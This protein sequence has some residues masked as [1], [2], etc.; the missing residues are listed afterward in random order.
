MFRIVVSLR[1]KRSTNSQYENATVGVDLEAS[2]LELS[3][4]EEIVGRTRQLFQIARSAVQGELLH[5]IPERTSSNGHT[6]GPNGNDHANGNGHHAAGHNGNGHGRSF[7]RPSPEPS[8]K[9]RVLLKRLADERRLTAEQVG[10]IARRDFGKNVPQLDRN[11][12]S[13]LLE[14]LMDQAVRP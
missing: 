3:T 7:G 1:E 11:E 13:R 5:A 4:P 8:A 2:G 6:D 12:M 9:Q 14:M 10:E